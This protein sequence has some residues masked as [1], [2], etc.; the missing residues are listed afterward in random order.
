MGLVVDLVSSVDEAIDFC[1][2]DLPQAII[3]EGILDG[4]RLRRLRADITTQIP[5]FPF[6][7]IVEEGAAYAMSG[8][9]GAPTSRVGREAIA[10]ALPSVVMY[11]L[12]R[13]L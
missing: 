9:G 2:E 11:E 6:I 1:R 5:G 8:F 4:E 10:S 12:S 13:S 3:V 7:E